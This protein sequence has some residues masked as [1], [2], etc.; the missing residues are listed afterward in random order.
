MTILK[1]IE[2]SRK[3]SHLYKSLQMPIQQPKYSHNLGM[4]DNYSLVSK[5]F[6]NFGNVEIW[7]G[8]QFCVLF[9]TA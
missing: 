7:K 5:F 6:F 9:Q 4:L 8:I 2:T 1:H 3:L